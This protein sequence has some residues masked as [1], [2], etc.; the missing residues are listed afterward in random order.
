MDLHINIAED[1]IR[2]TFPLHYDCI[3]RK[4]NDYRNRGAGNAYYSFDTLAFIDMVNGYSVMATDSSTV[5]RLVVLYSGQKEKYRV[6]EHK[7]MYMV[8]YNLIDKKSLIRNQ[9]RFG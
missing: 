2:D 6:S 5:K 1:F 8:T 7:Y 3:L 4:R 9:M